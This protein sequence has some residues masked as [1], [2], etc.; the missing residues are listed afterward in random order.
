MKKKRLSDSPKKNTKTFR[1]LLN[2]SIQRMESSHNNKIEGV[3]SGFTRIDDI[4]GGWQKGTFNVVAARPGMGRTAFILSIAR[5][6]TVDFNIPVAIFSLEMTAHHLINRII[7]S[8]TEIYADKLR[9]GRFNEKEF[10][11]IKAKAE[12]ISNAPIFIDDT[13]RLSISE[14]KEKAFRL[15]SEHNVSMIIIDDL[16]MMVSDQ[17]EK[18]D[19]KQEIGTIAN[20]LKTIS[21]ELDIPI[22]AVA[23]LGRDMEKRDNQ[24]PMLQDLRNTGIIEQDVDLV[25]FIYRPECHGIEKDEDGNSLE[26]IAEIIVAKHRNGRVGSENLFFISQFGKFVETSTAIEKSY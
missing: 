1:S 3:P 24:R 19:R 17:D 26:G 13:A 9:K 22:I 2:E 8:E 23:V 16:Q 6:A 11:N 5:N 15:K 10:D 4:T 20:S 25:L 18:T 14:F 21:K 7:G 12:K